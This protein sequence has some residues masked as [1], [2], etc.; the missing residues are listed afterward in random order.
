M[1]SSYFVFE[2][3]S[4]NFMS[5]F[6][7]NLF[8]DHPPKK[9]ELWATGKKLTLEHKILEAEMLCKAFIQF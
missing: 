3:G 7:K 4:K 2:A 1:V 9:G 8:S 6:T 5:T